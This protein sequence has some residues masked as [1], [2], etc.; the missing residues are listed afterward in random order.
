MTAIPAETIQ[1]KWQEGANSLLGELG[2]DKEFILSVRVDKGLARALEEQTKAWGLKN[3]SGTVRNILTFY[4]LPKIYRLEYEGK[5]VQYFKKALVQQKKEGISSEQ[6]KINYFLKALFDYM[7]FIEQTK[8]ASSETLR[9]AQ[10]T[11]KELNIAIMDMREKIQ[12]ALK[13]ME[14]G[15]K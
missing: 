11:E 5:Q 14:Q 4:F 1:Q 6:M 15:K 8:Q 12:Q 2:Q 10:E 13:E 9:F 3:M 7:T